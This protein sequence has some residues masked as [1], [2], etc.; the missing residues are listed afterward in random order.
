MKW[1]LAVVMLMALLLFFGLHKGAGDNVD[2]PL[3]APQIIAAEGKVEAMPG[4]EMD[5][6]SALT[7]RIERFLVKVGEHVDKGQ[8]IALLDDK[9]LA[10]QLQQAEAELAV[11][12]AKQGRARNSRWRKRS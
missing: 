4:A 9:D 8:V 6:G 5:V 2:M 1:K 12:K 7:V 10:A 3:P 11:A